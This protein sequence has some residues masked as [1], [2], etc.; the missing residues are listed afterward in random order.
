MKTQVRKNIL[1]HMWHVQVFEEPNT[2]KS[3]ESYNTRE[4]AE[5]RASEIAKGGAIKQPKAKKKTAQ[6]AKKTAKNAKGA[7]TPK[8]KKQ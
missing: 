6:N 3:V 4:E 7:K 1:T 2:W 5:K 8:E